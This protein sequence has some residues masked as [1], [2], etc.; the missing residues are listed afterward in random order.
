M[1]YI[2]P[3]LVEYVVVAAVLVAG[4]RVGVARLPRLQQPLLVAARQE[5]VLQD[6]L[7]DADKHAQLI[8]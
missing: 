8:S 2:L 5:L 3:G 4:A 6:R 7:Q 1:L